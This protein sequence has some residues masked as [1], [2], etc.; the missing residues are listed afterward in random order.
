[1]T[2]NR[3]RSPKSSPPSND[4]LARYWRQRAESREAWEKF[5]EGVHLLCE[6]G[7]FSHQRLRALAGKLPGGSLGNLILD[8]EYLATA[9]HWV[10]TSKKSGLEHNVTARLFGLPVVCDRGGAEKITG[11]YDSVV[12]LIRKAG[13]SQGDSGILLLPVIFRHE[14]ILLSNPGEF[15]DLAKGLLNIWFQEGSPSDLSTELIQ[16]VK[17]DRERKGRSRENGLGVHVILGVQVKNDDANGNFPVDVLQMLR[18]ETQLHVA[19]ERRLVNEAIDVWCDELPSEEGLSIL[20]PTSWNNLR[21]DLM[22]AQIDLQIGGMM[23]A[24]GD[25]GSVQEVEMDLVLSGS[26]LHIE[27]FHSKTLLLDIDIPLVAVADAYEEFLDTLH[28]QYIIRS[29]ITG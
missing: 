19:D 29:F 10:V 17:A 1:M 26:D 3:S 8:V 11:R 5:Q 18:G 4:A 27:A 9:A 15:Y 12:D 23:K 14:D 25:P 7:K 22:M 16:R 28:E 20:P 6:T 2:K 13:F 24:N 21:H